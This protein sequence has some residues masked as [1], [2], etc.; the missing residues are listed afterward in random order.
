MVRGT[1]AARPLGRPGGEDGKQQPAQHMVAVERVRPD[2]P[3]DRGDRIDGLPHPLEALVLHR[4][5]L[6][7]DWAR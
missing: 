6:S 2:P 3:T 1:I 7:G 5:I 4:D